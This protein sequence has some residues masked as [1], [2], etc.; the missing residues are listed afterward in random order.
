MPVRWSMRVVWCFNSVRWISCLIWMSWEG[1]ALA[2]IPI[3]MK[4]YMLI[5]LII[6]STFVSEPNRF[7]FFY[8]FTDA[9]LHYDI[10]IC[11]NWCLQRGMVQ[12]AHKLIAVD[13][14]IYK[15]WWVES[16]KSFNVNDREHFAQD[17]NVENIGGYQL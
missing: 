13:N 4:T 15:R 3:Q 12:F 6:P 10:T 16:C 11:Y 9:T 2:Q 17:S 1:H 7:N 14:W 5:E 8:K